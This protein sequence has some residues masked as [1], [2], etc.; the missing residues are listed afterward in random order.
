MSVIIAAYNEEPV[1]CRTIESVLSNGYP[2]P[3]IVIVNDG[4]KDRTLEVLQQRSVRTP[5]CG[6]FRN[7]TAASPR[8]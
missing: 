3:E 5:E 8:R 6:F 4:S 1:I 7:R 2:D